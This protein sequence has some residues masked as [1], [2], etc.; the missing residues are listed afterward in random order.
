MDLFKQINAFYSRVDYNPVSANAISLWFALVHIANKTGWLEYFTVAN[1]TLEAK[2]S[3][4]ISSLQRARNELIRRNLLV[5]SQG[6]NKNSVAKY[7][8]PVLYEQVGEQVNIPVVHNE[9]VTGQVS[10]QVTGQV[11]EHINKHKTKNI[12]HKTNNNCAFEQ[13]CSISK[14]SKQEINSFFDTVW[15]VYPNKKGKGQISDTQKVKLFSIGI[16]VLVKCIERYKS[17]KPDWQAFQNGSTFF[18]SGYVDYLDENYSDNP[19]QPEIKPKTNAFN[20]YSERHNY[21][22]EKLQKLENERIRKTIGENEDG[23]S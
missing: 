23:E 3:L 22:F 8:L 14:P 15:S 9:Q 16:E 2:S 17:G 1:K 5:Y 19:K 6:K 10:E 13:K 7:S 4:S 12:K 20:N 11:S 21:D 18:N